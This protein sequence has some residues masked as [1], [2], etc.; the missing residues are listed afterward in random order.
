MQF[1][2]R[3]CIYNIGLGNFRSPRSFSIYRDFVNFFQLTKITF[4]E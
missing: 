3:K 4:H 1:Y 2:D